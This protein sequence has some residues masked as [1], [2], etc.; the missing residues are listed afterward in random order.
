MLLASDGGSTDGRSL[1]GLR[2]LLSCLSF[3]LQLRTG[4]IS[5]VL[6]EPHAQMSF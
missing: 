2:S 6:G 5:S 1:F 4:V 3:R